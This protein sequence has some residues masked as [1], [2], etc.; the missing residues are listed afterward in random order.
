M[1]DATEKALWKRVR[2][3]RH[4]A[5]IGRR[6]GLPPSEL[7][8]TVV[9]VACDGP[10][11]TWGPLEDARR[12]LYRVLGE[13]A[14]S[15]EAPRDR[16]VLEIRRRLLGDLPAPTPEA[17]LVDVANRVARAFEGRAVLVI[18]ALDAADS[19]TL[20]AVTRVLS[21]GRLRLPLVLSF[22]AP[23]E[24]VARA[25][26]AALLEHVDDAVHPESAA[27]LTEPPAAPWDWSSLP[28]HL[29]LALRAAAVVGPVFEA[30]L[31]AAL[32]E[33][34]EGTVLGA[35][36][37]ARD[38]G[39]PIEDRGQGHL[40][41]REVDVMALR[42]TTMASLRNL[43]HGQVAELL[44]G[45]GTFEEEGARDLG[46]P[47]GVAAPAPPPVRRPD[48]SD[49]AE[50][51]ERAP[52]APAVEEAPV[53]SAEEMS[54]EEEPAPAPRARSAPVPARPA[55]DA[56][57]ARAARHLVQAGEPF[58]AVE[59]FHQ[60]MRSLLHRGDARRA[61]L[62]GTEAL[63]LLAKQPASRRQALQRARVLMDVGRAQWQAAGLEPAFTLEAALQSLE[64]AREALPADASLDLAGELAVVTAGVCY[65][66]GDLASLER[67]LGELSA[68]SRA[69]MSAGRPTEA[70]RLLNDQA[71]VLVRAGDPVQATHLLT[72]SR[73]LF[74]GLHR[75]R[76]DD[77]VATEELALTDHL[78]A[79]IPLHAPIRPGREQ[80]A[81]EMGLDHALSAE[82]LYR[83]LE[84]RRELGRV[85]ETM[86]RLEMRRDRLGQ[87][88]ER[89]GEALSLQRELG[90][91]T[92]LAR[93][94]AALSDV[95]AAGGRPT[96]AAALL[97][98]SVGLNYEKGS[99]LG[100]AFNR[101]ALEAL[102]SRAAD[103]RDGRELEELLDAV[104]DR[105]AGAE[106]ELGRIDLPGEAH[107]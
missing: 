7:G 51:F 64:A 100:L 46:A 77:R 62:V 30:H 95:L 89:L 24:G 14:P 6:V 99:P 97:A 101:R 50:V 48:A 17:D 82:R 103:L 43:W 104:E 75:Q 29:L 94:T 85:W 71:A 96:D 84:H 40:A 61:F 80:D 83:G 59:R 90:D 1:D 58:A 54:R 12:G 76:P 81:C 31:V 20:E 56:D 44:A 34:S 21:E 79:R 102:R 68:S 15:F 105:L 8:L 106:E 25:P 42:E 72:R 36:Q 67:A 5:V 28:G 18:E 87:A 26:L 39:A 16:A 86:G 63:S 107:P 19:A 45:Q 37:R 70:A 10:S 41:L 9:R 4:G 49:Y 35:L 55:P 3:G 65:D 33:S 93:T 52:G 13:V 60:A 47:A 11:T 98:D 53:Q 92:G 27:P 2:S 91:V 69:L 74:E 66:R 38:L 73:D 22:T 88:S 78:L 23:P 32:L 57:A